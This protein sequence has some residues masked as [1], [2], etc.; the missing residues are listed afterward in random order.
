MSIALLLLLAL[1]FGLAGWLAARAKAWSFRRSGTARLAALPSYHG[2]YLAMWVF[3]P[4]V[5]FIALWGSIAPELITIKGAKGTL[6]LPLKKGVTVKQEEKKLAIG[7]GIVTVNTMEQAKARAET[8]RGD[9]GGD[10]AHACLAMIA[11]QRRWR[12]S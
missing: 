3:I 11:L 10:A 9:K 7:Y 1:G 4:T 12:K 8:H 2:W 5:A 6:T